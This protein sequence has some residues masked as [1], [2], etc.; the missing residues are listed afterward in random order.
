MSHA[1]TKSLSRRNVLVSVV[2]LAPALFMGPA[3]AAGLPPTAV[4]YQATPKDGKQ[5]SD[6]KLFISPNACKSVTGE[7]APTGWCKLYAKKA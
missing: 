4:G 7:I 3:K 6:C 2:G 1:G 5:C